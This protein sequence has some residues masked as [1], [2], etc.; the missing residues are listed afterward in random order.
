[1]WLGA[2]VTACGMGLAVSMKEEGNGVDTTWF[3]PGGALTILGS[4][5]VLLGAV[6][7]GALLDTLQALDAEPTPTAPQTHL[8]PE[9]LG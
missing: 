1:M 5:L 2:I 8:A 4:V 3:R 7:V 6:A 9:G